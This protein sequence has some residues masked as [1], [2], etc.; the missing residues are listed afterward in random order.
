MS[1]EP[2]FIG[3]PDW[4]T[5]AW[6]EREYTMARLKH[7]RYQKTATAKSLGISLKTLYNRL[8]KYQAEDRKQIESSMALKEMRGNETGSGLPTGFCQ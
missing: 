3:D 2:E 6:V 7:F 8:A 1:A 4:P 5:L